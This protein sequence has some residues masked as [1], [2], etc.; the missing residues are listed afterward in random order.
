MTDAQLS[1][2]DTIP[3]DIPE[4]VTPATVYGHKGNTDYGHL[5]IA[6]PCGDWLFLWRGGP[7][8]TCCLP[9]W[10]TAVDLDAEQL[11]VLADYCGQMANRLEKTC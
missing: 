6:A 1:L 2:L 3:D 8:I 7:T 10:D 5:L 11:R 4:K 9:G